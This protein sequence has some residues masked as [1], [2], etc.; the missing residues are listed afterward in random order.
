MPVRVLV[1]QP[2]VHAVSLSRLAALEA[3]VATA[4]TTVQKRNRQMLKGVP[5]LKQNSL[6]RRNRIHSHR[7]SGSHRSISTFRIFRGQTS[8]SIERSIECATEAGRSLGSL[9]QR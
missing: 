9:Q 1:T 5:F 6:I 8:Q 7:L 2:F 3:R 4:Y